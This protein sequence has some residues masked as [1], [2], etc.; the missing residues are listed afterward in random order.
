MEDALVHA[1]FDVLGID[2]GNV[3]E[4]HETLFFLTDIHARRPLAGHDVGLITVF[5][6][7]LAE[8]LFHLFLEAVEL[9]P[10]LITY[11]CH[12]CLLGCESGTAGPH[13]HQLWALPLLSRVSPAPW[14]RYHVT[15]AIIEGQPMTIQVGDRIPNV[16]LNYLK[17][18]V[19]AI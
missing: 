12:D 13:A 1:D 16:T 18:G 11:D 7:E 4:D 6:K 5:A 15:S 9:A 2:P 14:R 10:G 3:G 19:Q 17:D 8:H